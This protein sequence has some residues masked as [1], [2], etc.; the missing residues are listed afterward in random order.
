MK[1]PIETAGQEVDGG[2]CTETNQSIILSQSR[3]KS[4]Q[5]KERNVENPPALESKASEEAAVTA[6]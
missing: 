3:F 5:N 6:P 1:P 4:W 2:R